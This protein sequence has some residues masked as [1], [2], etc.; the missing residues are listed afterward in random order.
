[1]ALIQTNHFEGYGWRSFDA[2]VGRA[3]FE[4]D[5]MAAAENKKIKKR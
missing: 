1:M 5:R 4:L 2:F 3:Q